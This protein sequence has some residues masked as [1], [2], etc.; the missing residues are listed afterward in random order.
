LVINLKHPIVWFLLSSL[1]AVWLFVASKSSI[2]PRYYIGPTATIA[3]SLNGEDDL[4]VLWK[5]EEIENA[6]STKIALWN[7]G[8]KYLDRLSISNDAPITVSISEGSKILSH[9][10]LKVSRESLKFDIKKVAALNSNSLIISFKN[11][12]ALEQNDGLLIEVL[13]T[14]KSDSELL[15]EGRIKGVPDGFEEDQLFGLELTEQRATIKSALIALV[16]VALIGGGINLYHGIRQ[17]KRQSKHCW[18]CLTSGGGMLVI[19]ITAS[20]YI[21]QTVV[22][23]LSWL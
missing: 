16:I 3:S 10:V 19:S 13:H 8:S 7:A 9:K 2:E 1:V 18:F 20:I 11:D 4:K 14:G 15:I 17:Y 21:V 5:G 22:F 6:K 23:G 12:E